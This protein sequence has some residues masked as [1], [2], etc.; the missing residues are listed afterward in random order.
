MLTDYALALLCLGFA[1]L[2]W[3]RSSPLGRRGVGMWIVAFFVTAIAAIFGGTA[4][5][6]REPLGSNW[7]VVWR[8]TVASI[9]LSSVLLIGAGVRSALHP[10]PATPAAR[11]EGLKWLKRGVAVTLIALAVLVG[12][13]S[14]HEHFNHNDLFHVIQMGGLYCLFRAVRL[15]HDLT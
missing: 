13:L 2:L 6:F 9:A 10:K 14:L 8:L 11:S 15:L 1:L 3:R 5:G 7:T 12:R 4:H